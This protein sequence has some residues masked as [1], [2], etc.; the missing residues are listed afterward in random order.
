MLQHTRE[1]EGCADV[2][3]MSD[4]DWDGRQ[5][6][7]TSSGIDTPVSSLTPRECPPTPKESDPHQRGPPETSTAVPPWAPDLAPQ[8]RDSRLT[9]DPNHRR[10]EQ[11]RTAT[12][13]V[14]SPTDPQQ[15]VCIRRNVPVHSSWTIRQQISRV[16]LQVRCD[17][18]SGRIIV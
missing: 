6:H 5:Y 18:G 2:V 12:T 1:T 9:P 4:S 13:G 16:I 10:P 14:A 3:H 11:A 17:R 7:M 8:Q 15:Q